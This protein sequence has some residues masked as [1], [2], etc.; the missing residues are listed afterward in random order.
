M[1]A[2]EAWA[3]ARG[4]AA[5]SLVTGNPESRAFYERIGYASEAEPRARRVIFGPTGEARGLAA[6]AKLRM[7]R[8][9]LNVNRTILVKHLK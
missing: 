5:V 6:A 8:R 2:V 3:A 1:A 4:Y 7:L 9:R